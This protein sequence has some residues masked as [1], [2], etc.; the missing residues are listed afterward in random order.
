ML[1][2]VPLSAFAVMGVLAV[3][4]GPA[5]P[6]ADAP[7]S[8]PASHQAFE[9]ADKVVVRKGERRMELLRDGR[10]I[11]T[12]RIALGL[13]PDGHKER[14]GD[15]RTPEGRYWLTRRNTDSDYFL[16]IQISY[17]NEHDI[18]RARRQGVPPGGAIMIHGLPNHPRH[19]PDFYRNHD[20]TDGCIAISNSEMLEL[21]LLTRPSTPIEI[22]P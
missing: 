9:V 18:A 7:D 15:F 8:N 11:A 4:P 2:I 16:S 12:Y 6:P 10:P 5:Q 20:W 21:W 14:E 3:T 1:K 13:D 19:G 17:P 22:L